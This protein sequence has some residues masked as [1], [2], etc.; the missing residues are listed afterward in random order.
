MI[1]SLQRVHARKHICAARGECISLQDEEIDLDRQ[2]SHVFC[3][4]CVDLLRLP[5]VFCNIRCYERHF[6]KHREAVHLPRRLK[7]GLVRDDTNEL[8]FKDAAKT[9]Y[10]PKDLRGGVKTWYEAVHWWENHFHI[11]FGPA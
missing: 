4:E 11:E 7:K 8:V 9:R 5:T 10:A 3:K 6:Q 1:S 2:R